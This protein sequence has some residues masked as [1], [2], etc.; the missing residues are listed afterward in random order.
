[1]PPYVAIPRQTYMTRPTYLGEHHRAFEVGNP[2]S[3]GYDV[4]TD[5]GPCV[6]PDNTITDN[7]SALDVSSLSRPCCR[8]RCRTASGTGSVFSRRTAR[9]VLIAS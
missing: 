5:M 7:M 1:M 9:S 8:I 3:P 4:E 2:T 6:G